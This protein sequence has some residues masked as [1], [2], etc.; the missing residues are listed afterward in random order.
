M[1]KEGGAHPLSCPDGLSANGAKF[2]NQNGEEDQ[3]LQV[4]CFD[5]VGRR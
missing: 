2:V 4:K 1:K 3:G 5:I